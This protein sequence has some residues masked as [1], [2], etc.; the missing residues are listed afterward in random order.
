MHYFHV[1]IALWVTP[2]CLPL[3]ESEV[4]GQ[5]GHPFNFFLDLRKGEQGLGSERDVSCHL[6]QLLSESHV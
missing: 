6:V 2:L 5:R 1:R 4:P 3:A